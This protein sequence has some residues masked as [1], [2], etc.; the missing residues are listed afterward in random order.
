[1][2]VVN[3]EATK[4]HTEDQQVKHGL[5]YVRI[6]NLHNMASVNATMGLVAKVDGTDGEIEHRDVSVSKAEIMA[7]ASAEEKA[8]AKTFLAMMERL[9]CKKVDKLKDLAHDDSDVFV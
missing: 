5:Y 3:T 8:A 1:M 9:A 7:E 2:S 4:Y 6:N